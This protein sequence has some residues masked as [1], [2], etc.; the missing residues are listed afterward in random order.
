[1]ATTIVVCS[2]LEP[3]LV[4]R[5]AREDDVTVVYRPDLLPT[6]RY[7]CDHTGVRRE[8]TDAQV[9]EWRTALASADV[10]FDFDWLDPARMPESCPRLG[11]V[12]ATS[13]GI[14]A[15]MA[16]TGLDASTITATTA[17]GIHAVPLAEF[18]LMGALHFTKG[19][20]T[21]RR[22]QEAHHWERFTTRQLRGRR[23]LVVGLGGMGREVARLLGAVG[24]EVWGMGRPGRTY[25]VAGLARVVERAELDAA[26][27]EVDI[28]VLASPLT[29]ETEGMI[30][31][32]QVAALPRDAVVVNLSR[33]QLID[34]AALTEALAEGRLAGA[35]LDV[36]EVEPLPADDPL[37]ELDNVIVS[38]HSA[39]TV[40]TENEALVEL[41]LDNLGRWRR[42][43]GMRNLYDPVA[44]Y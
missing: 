6:P 38:P 41:F 12:Q 11:W 3:E 33:G 20:P 32:A 7:L 1:M 16:R 13:A 26:L 44:G 31:R 34:Q 19:L 18:A 5:I 28:L 27:G 2:Y 22:W 24:V 10:C 14:G 30:G 40:A 25:D 21:L 29:R 15:F 4:E 8:L 37:W 23:A 39:S 17:G 36:F 43:E 35:C 42:G 9:D